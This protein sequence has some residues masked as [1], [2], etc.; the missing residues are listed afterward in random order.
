MFTFAPARCPLVTK[1]GAY[2]QYTVNKKRPPQ[3]TNLNCETTPALGA[4]NQ[5]LGF[6]W[7]F[8]TSHSCELGTRAEEP[9]MKARTHIRL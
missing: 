3:T 9:T 8:G 6:E 1:I 2:V 5:E 4:R 7:Q